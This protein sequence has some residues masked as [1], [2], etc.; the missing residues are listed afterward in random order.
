MVQD[1]PGNRFKRDDL[2]DAVQFDRLFWHAEDDAG[3]FV[4]GDC[5]GA[6]LL[7]LEHAARAIVSHAGEDDSDGVRAGVSGGGTEEHVD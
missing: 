3:G 6:G 7:H 1:R 5:C 2:V 4:L